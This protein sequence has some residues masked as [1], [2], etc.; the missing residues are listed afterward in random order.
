MPIYTISYKLTGGS[1]AANTTPANGTATGLV[2]RRGEVEDWGLH[3]LRE[4][5]FEI[6]GAPQARE[7]L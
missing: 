1:V 7:I 6:W 4:I 3:T 2:G 5:L